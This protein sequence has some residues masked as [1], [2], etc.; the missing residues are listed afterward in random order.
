VSSVHLALGVALL[1]LD[2]RGTIALLTPAPETLQLTS[3]AIER[4]RPTQRRERAG[5]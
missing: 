3:V 1:L 5:P 2:A 4:V